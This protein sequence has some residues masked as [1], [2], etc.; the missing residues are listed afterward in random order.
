LKAALHDEARL[1]LH[2]SIFLA[3][4]ALVVLRKIAILRWVNPE[5]KVVSHSLH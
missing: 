4:V 5:E 3:I 1:T 2:F